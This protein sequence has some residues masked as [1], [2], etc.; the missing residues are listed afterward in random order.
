MNWVDIVII[1]ICLLGCLIGVWKGFFKSIFSLISSSLVFFLSFLVCKPTASWIMKITTWDN[2]LNSKIASWLSDISPKF[3]LNMVGMN[4][5][6]LSKHISSTLSSDG[7]P[8]FFKFLF[9]TTTSISPEQI[10]HKQ[11]FTMGNMISQTLTITTF[12]IAC[13]IIF[14]ILFFVVKFLIGK[15]TKRLTEKSPTIKSVDKVFGGIFGIA[16]GLVWV[17]IIFAFYSIFK[18]LPALK[19]VTTTI[20]K[21]AIGSPLSEWIYKI[22]DKYFNL[23]TMINMIS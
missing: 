4:A 21:S 22:I 20:S 7:F 19:T 14:F 17:L 9:K 12:V 1:I 16:R 10:A 23:Q 6:E 11:S 13:F 18:N 8:K 15:L 2:S 3:D 5:S